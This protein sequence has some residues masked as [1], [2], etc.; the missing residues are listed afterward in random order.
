MFI[1]VVKNEKIL[2]PFFPLESLPFIL[3]SYQIKGGEGA[4][5]EHVMLKLS[6]LAS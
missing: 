3:K 1:I 2:V 4:V 6:H 5:S